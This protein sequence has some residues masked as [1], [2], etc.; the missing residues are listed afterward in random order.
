M[1]CCVFSS[2]SIILLKVAMHTQSSGSTGLAIFLKFLL[3][4]YSTSEKKLLTLAM[5]TSLCY[6]V[7][8]RSFNVFVLQYVYTVLMLQ[9]T[10]VEHLPVL[11]LQCSCTLA[12]TVSPL[13][14]HYG[15]GSIVDTHSHVVTV[16]PLPPTWTL[17]V[18]I[19]HS[20]S[21]CG[22]WSGLPVHQT[23]LSGP[24]ISDLLCSQ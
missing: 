22:V 3:S 24:L 12:A 10:P 13:V 21:L 20:L 19:M 9:I 16:R 14:S 17:I 23:P 1:N 18:T 2:L 5:L 4:P 11:Y 15:E 7:S 6:Y 8:T